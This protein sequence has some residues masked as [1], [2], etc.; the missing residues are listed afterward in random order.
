MDFPTFC[1]LQR[2]RVRASLSL[3]ED[4]RDSR[5]RNAKSNPE[6]YEHPNAAYEVWFEDAPDKRRKDSVQRGYDLLKLLYE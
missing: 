3:D 4:I 1:E 6:E 2:Q 5:F